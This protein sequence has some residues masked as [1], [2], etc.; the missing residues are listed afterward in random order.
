VSDE[1]TCRRTLL[2]GAGAAGVAGL[3]GGCAAYGQGDPPAAPA[4]PARAAGT[5]RADGSTGGDGTTG[6]STTGGPATGSLAKVADIPIGGGKIFAEQKVV[7]TRPAAGT[8]KAFSTTCTHQGCALNEIAGGTINCP[9]HGSR[10]TIADGEPAAGPAKRALDAVAISVDG[11]A[12]T[13][14]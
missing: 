4:Q 7:V 6:N 3:L 5:K 10:F 12:I 14:S 13:L 1:G 8:I 2:A 11:D 9:C